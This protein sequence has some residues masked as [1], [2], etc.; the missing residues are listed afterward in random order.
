[1]GVS[2]SGQ[3]APLRSAPHISDISSLG[4]RVRDAQLI[5]G[6]SRLA[7]TLEIYT[8]E[9]RQAQRDALGRINDALGHSDG[10]GRRIGVKRG[11]SL[12]RWGRSRQRFWL[13][14][15]AGLEP[16]TRCLEGSRS[17]LAELPALETLLCTSKV[18]C[19][20]HR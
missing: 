3:T 18:T 17:I 11:V 7:V 1:M 14:R 10:T 9:D 8:H 20:T 2:Q 15:R 12:L 5:L 6:H 13:A 4:V 16:A 19:W